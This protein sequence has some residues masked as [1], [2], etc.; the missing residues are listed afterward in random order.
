M[1]EN[2]KTLQ[3]YLIAVVFAEE[4]DDT[5]ENLIFVEFVLEKKQIFENYQVWENQ[6]GKIVLN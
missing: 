1:V 6:V 4:Q 5:Y 3:K 2:Q